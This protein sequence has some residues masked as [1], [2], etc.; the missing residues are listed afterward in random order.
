MGKM[1]THAAGSDVD[2]GFLAGVAVT[3]GASE[4]AEA[5]LRSATTARHFMELVLQ[6]KILGVFDALCKKICEQCRAY[7]K[8][9]LTVEA[10]M[11]DF[12]G[13]VIGRAEL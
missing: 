12:E 5:K 6:E 4:Q 3:C 9:P 8:Y 10:I 13:R 7:L 1:Q 2:I 11:T